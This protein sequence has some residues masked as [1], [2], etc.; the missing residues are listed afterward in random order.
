MSDYD[1]DAY[2][3]GPKSASYTDRLL[4]RGDDSRDE[5]KGR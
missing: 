3:G 5:V 2:D 4:D 1:W